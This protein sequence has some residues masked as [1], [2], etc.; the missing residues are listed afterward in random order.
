M[1]KIIMLV[2]VFTFAI[3]LTSCSWGEEVLVKFLDISVDLDDDG[4]EGDRSGEFNYNVTF[5]GSGPKVQSSCHISGHNCAYGID[6]NN[7]GWC[8]NCYANG[9]YCHMARHSN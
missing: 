1:K 4:D 5:R 9:H 8:D 7:D 6:K 2:A 3:S